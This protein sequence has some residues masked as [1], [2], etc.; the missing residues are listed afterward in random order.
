MRT[1]LGAALAAGALAAGAAGAGTATTTFNVTA[2]VVA[3]CT[4]SATNL[5]FGSYTPGSVAGYLTGSSTITMKCTTG[6]KPTVA[7][8]AGGGTYA[9]RQMASTAT[10]AN[11][12]AYQIYTTSTTTGTGASVWGDGVTGDNTSTLQVATASTGIGTPLTLTVNGLILDTMGTNLAAVPAT[13]YK[14]TIVATI[15]Y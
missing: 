6:A 14:D 4:A 10:P 8:S 15:T 2:T 5:A 13:D 3:S 1:I 7:L 9:Q 12:L 11:K